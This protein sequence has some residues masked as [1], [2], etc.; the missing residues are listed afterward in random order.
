MARHS[1]AEEDL[2]LAKATVKGIEK[3]RDELVDA[4]RDKISSAEAERLILNRW[5]RT[6]ATVFDAR[7][8]AYRDSLVRQIESLRSKYAVALDQLN[9]LRQAKADSASKLLREFGYE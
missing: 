3:K 4:A 7:L 9:M 8:D 2:K 5:M 6:L 1:Q